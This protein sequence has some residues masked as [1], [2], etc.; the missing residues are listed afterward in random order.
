MM[1]RVEGLERLVEQLRPSTRDTEG[2]SAQS[3]SPGDSMTHRVGTGSHLQLLLN[4]MYP[5]RGDNDGQTWKVSTIDRI[6][7]R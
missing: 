5:Y 6:C 2:Q 7:D 1:E 3:V 4:I